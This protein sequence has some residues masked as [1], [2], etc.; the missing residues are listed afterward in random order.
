MRPAQVAVLLLLLVGYG[1]FY[2]CR[3]NLD[4]AGPLLVLGGMSKTS[5][6]LLTTVATLTYGVGKMVLGAGGD[7]LGGRRLMGLAIVGS[8]VFTLAFGVSHAF[9]A[10]VAF[11]ALNRFFQSGGWSALVH[12]VSRWFEPRRHGL[13]MGIL[14]TSY[15]L[16][17][18]CALNFCGFVSRWGWRALFLVNPILFA[19]IGGTVVLSLRGEPSAHDGRGDHRKTGRREDGK[20]WGGRHWEQATQQPTLPV[21][22]SSCPL[23]LPSASRSAPSC[24]ASSRAAR[25]GPRSR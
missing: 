15:E 17:N 7:V 12:V 25:S 13:V 3:A 2:L 1:S 20:V 10:L 18:V 11:A 21:F 22:P 8:V 4:A 5:F 24:R 16:G 6:G 9:V 23:P 14:A 19:I